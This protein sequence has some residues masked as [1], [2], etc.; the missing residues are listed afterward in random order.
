LATHDDCPAQIVLIFIFSSA[1]GTSSWLLCVLEADEIIQS[2]LRVTHDRRYDGAV[3]GLQSACRAF[4]WI[5]EQV[6]GPE[7]AKRGEGFL[8]FVNA[9]V[10]E[11]A[12]GSGNLLATHWLTGELPP[13]SEKRLTIAAVEATTWEL[14]GYTKGPSC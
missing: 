9:Q 13:F 8:D 12:A 10:A 1:P 5:V 3:Y 4:G 11:I 6:Y 14:G 7:R 2:S